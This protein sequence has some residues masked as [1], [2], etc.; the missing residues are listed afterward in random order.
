MGSRCKV[1]FEF[2]K[3]LTPSRSGIYIRY[4]KFRYEKNTTLN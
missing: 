2:V 3:K 1:K 4:V